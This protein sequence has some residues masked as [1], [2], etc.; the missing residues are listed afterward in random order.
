MNILKRIDLKK[1]GQSINVRAINNRIS[2][3]KGIQDGFSLIEAVEE[4]LL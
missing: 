1:L 2:E 4:S 3:G